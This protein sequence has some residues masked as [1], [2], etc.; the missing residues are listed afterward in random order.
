MTTNDKHYN[1]AVLSLPELAGVGGVLQGFVF[2]NCTLQGPAVLI[3]SGCTFAGSGF[4]GDADSVL[5]EIPEE[6]QWALGAI[7]ARDC[8]FEDCTLQNVGL[9]GKREFAQ[10]FRRATTAP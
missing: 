10:N 4:G 8:T 2:V 5:W 1:D 3:P 9:A 6:R 7:S